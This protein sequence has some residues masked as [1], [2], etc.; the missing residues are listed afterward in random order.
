MPIADDGDYGVLDFT[1]EWKEVPTCCLNMKVL[2]AMG[3]DP[4]YSKKK[5]AAFSAISVKGACPYCGRRYLIDY[6][7]GRE[8]AEQ[9]PTTIGTFTLAYPDI[10]EVRIESVAAQKALITDPRLVQLAH[11]HNFEITEWQTDE[12][13]WDPVLGIPQSARHVKNGMYSVPYKTVADQDYA[14]RILKQLIRWPKRPNDWVMADWFAEISL[15]QMIEDF[16][17]VGSELMLGEDPFRSEWHD[18]QVT[19]FD[20]QA[21]FDGE[22]DFEYV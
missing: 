2:V 4:A 3:F 20:M 6:W 15:V 17:Y 19:E 5:T 8:S 14:E 21:D 7:E 13:K 16:R 10:S 1:R 9:H 18:E 11:D 12:R 22:G